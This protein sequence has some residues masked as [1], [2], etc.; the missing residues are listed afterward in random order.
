MKLYDISLYLVYISTYSIIIPVITGIYYLR[1]LTRALGFL[2][3]GLYAVVFL[4]LLLLCFDNRTANNLLYFFTA[5]DVLT[6]SLV[7]YFS[8]RN[9]KVRTGVLATGVLFVPL[10]AMDAFF[11]S[12]PNNNGYSSSLEKI[13]VLSTSIYYLK[14]L[15]QEDNDEVDI[16]KQPMFW[17]CSSV[18]ANNLVASFDV[19]RGPIMNYSQNL[20]LQFYI[21]WS[22]LTFSMYIAFAYSFRLCKNMVE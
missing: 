13:F 9:K 21:F 20:Y 3:Y 15:L 8:I 7:F 17:I 10:I 22:L 4:D 19:F 16:L 18:A 14:Q 12:G 5:V 6:M 1:F 11:L 2:L